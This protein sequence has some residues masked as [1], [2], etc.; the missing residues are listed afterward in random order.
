V[1]SLI[2]IRLRLLKETLVVSIARSLWQAFEVLRI[3]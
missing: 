3:P 1:V 2:L